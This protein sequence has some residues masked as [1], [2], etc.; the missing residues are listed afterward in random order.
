ML[1]T[2]SADGGNV[3]HGKRPSKR[4]AGDRPLSCAGAGAAIVANAWATQ[5]GG[6]KQQSIKDK[7]KRQA[8][9]GLALAHSQ[10][11]DQGWCPVPQKQPPTHNKRT[12]AKHER[13]PPA[14]RSR[15]PTRSAPHRPRLA[16]RTNRRVTTPQRASD[17]KIPAPPRVRHSSARKL[18]CL[19]KALCAAASLQPRTHSRHSSRK[20]KQ[21]SEVLW[22]SLM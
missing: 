5:R 6:A 17:L 16:R 4:S 21:A 11:Y 2:A 19:P 3:G 7:P 13:K 12:A 18:P 1:P 20:K 15:L 14:A 10:P 9:T 8:E 22:H